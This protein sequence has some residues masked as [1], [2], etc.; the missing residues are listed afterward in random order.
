MLQ[1]DDPRPPGRHEPVLGC[2]EE[3]VQQDQR[4]NADELQEDSHGAALVL[5]GFSSTS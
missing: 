5:G 3:G 1:L 4:R 2:D